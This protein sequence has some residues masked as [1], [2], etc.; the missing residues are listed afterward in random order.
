MVRNRYEAV[1]RPKMV[2]F[3][4]TRRYDGITAQAVHFVGP[5]GRGV[6]G[7]YRMEQ[8]EDGSWRINGV[9]MVP[10]SDIAS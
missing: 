9:Q 6:I 10:A 5:D 8:Q 7:I 1:Y 3:L 4:D 2:E